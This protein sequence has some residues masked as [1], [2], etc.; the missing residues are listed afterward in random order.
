MIFINK[1]MEYYKS[2]EYILN[3]NYKIIEVENEYLTYENNNKK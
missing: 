3:K 1:N 2:V